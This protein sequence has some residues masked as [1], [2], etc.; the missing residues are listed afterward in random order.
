MR[1]GAAPAG[2]SLA[3][4]AWNDLLSGRNGRRAQMS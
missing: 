2:G 3:G 4:A 1:N